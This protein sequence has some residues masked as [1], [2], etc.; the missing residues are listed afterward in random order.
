MNFQRASPPFKNTYFGRISACLSVM[1]PLQPSVAFLY[2][3]MFS[4]GIGKQRR[5][6]MG[7][8][9][10]RDIILDH[11]FIQSTCTC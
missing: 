4:E 1:N 8:I 2:P 3:L 7:L 10:F 5:A 9:L 11:N 6:V